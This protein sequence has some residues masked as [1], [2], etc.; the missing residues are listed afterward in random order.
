M[1]RTQIYRDE[2]THQRLNSIAAHRAMTLSQIIREAISRYIASGADTDPTA[3]IDR[4]CGLWADYAA[5]E[6]DALSLRA[7]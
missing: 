4:A 6:I 3:V 1:Q 7:G 2:A 5:D